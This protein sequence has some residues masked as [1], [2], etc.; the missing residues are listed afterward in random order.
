MGKIKITCTKK[1]KQALLR[2]ILRRDTGC[3]FPNECPEGGCEQ[4]IKEN[5]EF[6]IKEDE[7]YR[8]SKK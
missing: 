8:T 7:S 2:S 6:T 4:C 5:M 1:Q 3:P